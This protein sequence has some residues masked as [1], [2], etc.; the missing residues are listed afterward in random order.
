MNYLIILMTACICIISAYALGGDA[1]G[2]KLTDMFFLIR[3]IALPFAVV[4]IAGSAIQILLG[5]A[6][7]TEKAF[8]RMYSI[9]LAYGGIWALYKIAS[10]GMRL[11]GEWTPH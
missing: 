2:A 1:A 3:N 8:R 4:G 5:G 6:N 9:A 7:S 11:F 10:S